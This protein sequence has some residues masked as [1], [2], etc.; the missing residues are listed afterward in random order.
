MGLAGM[1]VY[2]VFQEA[3]YRHGCFG[4]FDSADMAVDVARALAD[5]DID[6]HHTYEVVQFDLNTALSPSSEYGGAREQSAL[7][8]FRRK[9]RKARA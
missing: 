4:I 2:A 1:K 7:A 8:S 9:A 3:V 6:D 5:A